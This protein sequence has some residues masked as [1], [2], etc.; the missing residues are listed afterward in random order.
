VP[1][2]VYDNLRTNFG[3]LRL[4]NLGARKRPKFYAISDNFKIWSRI[5]P[6]RMKI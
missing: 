1:Q 4:W 2:D 3:G 5:Y 6:G